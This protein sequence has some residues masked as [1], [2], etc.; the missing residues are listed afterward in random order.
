MN[1]PVRIGINALYLIPGGVGGTEIYLRSLIQALAEVDAANE[2]FVFTNAETD[3]DLVPQRANFHHVPQSV[4]AAVRP[5]RLSWEQFV[6]PGR[7]R[8]L[9]LDVLFNPGFTSPLFGGCPNVTVFHDLQHKRHPEY[10]RWFDLPFWRFF[11]YWSARRSKRLIAVS[12][13]TRLDLLRYYPVPDAKIRVVPHGVDEAFFAVGQQRN[14]GELRHFILC[15]ST[16]HPH[17]NLDRL[18]RA[19]R[20][21]H[22][23]RPQY[24]LII[25]GMHGFQTNQIERTII[26]CGMGAHVH[27][28]GWIPREELLDLYHKAWAF[29]YPS[30]FEG[31]GM[32]VLEALASGI[33]S[34]VSAIEPMKGIAGNA[35]LQFHP[36]E[37]EEIAAAL[38]RI[39][40]DDELRARL[41]VAGPQRAADFSWRTAA[42]QTLRVLEAAAN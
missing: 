29:V 34:A 31:F 35:A 18:V 3:A 17:K 39:V 1:R 37:E 15:V 30:T 5:A 38:E 21:L 6:L 12:E 41:C 11:L 14:E 2:Y 9:K 27:I 24:R 19:F 4:H 7:A 36:L 25:A 23:R 26:E 40:T 28:T 10:F 8:G 42:Q 32:P 13:S 20:R 33:P 16:L 22:A